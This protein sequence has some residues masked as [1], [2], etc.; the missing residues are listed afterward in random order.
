MVSLKVISCNVRGILDKVKRCKLFLYAKMNKADVVFFQE[1]HSDSKTVKTWKSEWRGELF[2]AH[3]TNQ[4]RG[5]MI[6][7]NPNLDLNI[8]KVQADESGR[9]F[10]VQASI[11]D[12]TYMFVNLYAPNEDEP[13]FFCNLFK[14][15]TL[16]EYDHVILG[17][18][19]NVYL[20][21]EK[22]GKPIR[23]KSASF[24]LQFMEEY[25]WIDIWRQFH[26]DTF[27]YGS[28]LNPLSGPG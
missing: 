23:S 6:G 19:F 1:T 18:D 13:S 14:K 5:V 26:P 27:Q 15:V 7:F 3:G 28:K 8:K 25:Q 22:G 2:S 9:Y 10:I 16:Q 17:G 11:D 20:D 24:I 12:K 4:S 21:P